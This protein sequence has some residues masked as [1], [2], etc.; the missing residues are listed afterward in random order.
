MEGDKI[1]NIP[2]SLLELER[3]ERYLEEKAARGFLFQK[4]ESSGLKGRFQET[5]GQS[6]YFSLGLYDGKIGKKRKRR[7]TF[8]I[9]APNGRAGDGFL[10]RQWEIWLF[11][12]AMKKHGLRSR[13]R[14]GLGG[15]KKRGWR[16]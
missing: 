11:F 4:F 10:Q 16:F 12:G 8:P 5:A 3:L 7:R 2:Y 14:N 1:Y 15:R 13:K 9:F 6:W